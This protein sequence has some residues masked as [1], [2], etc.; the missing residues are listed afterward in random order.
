MY[1]FVDVEHH[2]YTKD[3]GQTMRNMQARPCVVWLINTMD[4]RQQFCEHIVP[5]DLRTEI[6]FDWENE[7]DEEN[8]KGSY[9]EALREQDR[10]F[11]LNFISCKK[12]NENVIGVK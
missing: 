7:E 5:L 1:E 2:W 10:T 12:R 11:L 8:W 6:N 4:K 9:E 3:N